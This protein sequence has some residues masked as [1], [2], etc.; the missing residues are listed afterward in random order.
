[1]NKY[2]L[3]Q[4]G[5]SPSPEMREKFR[6]GQQRRRAAIDAEHQ[7][8]LDEFIAKVQVLLDECYRQLKLQ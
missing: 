4:R 1:M 8:H 7:R 5:V 6:E 2:G 3:F